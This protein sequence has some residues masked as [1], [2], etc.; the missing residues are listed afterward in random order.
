MPASSKRDLLLA[1]A[2]PI[3]DGSSAS[4][5]TCLRGEKKPAEGEWSENM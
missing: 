3:S 1:K 2:E 5:T 4:R